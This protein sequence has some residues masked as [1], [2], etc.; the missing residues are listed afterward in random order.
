MP[1]PT[2]VATAGAADANVYC[3]RAFA[4]QFHLERVPPDSTWANAQDKDKDRA[5]V[6]A[7]R[8]F[9]ALYEWSGWVVNDTQALLWPRSGM[10]YRSGHAVPTTVIPVDLQRATAEFARQ[11][12]ASDR[13]SDSSDLASQ[14]ITALKVGP[15]SIDFEGSASAA[16]SGAVIPD[17]VASMLPASWGYVRGRS[18]VIDLVR[19]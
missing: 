12:L 3:T 17:I 5:L 13:T 15:I 9:D 6:Y 7:T 14:G 1:L 8:L 2:L 16:E 19:C 10:V 4:D 18:G 11:L